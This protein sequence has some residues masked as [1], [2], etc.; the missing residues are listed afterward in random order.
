MRMVRVDYEWHLT[1]ELLPFGI[2]LVSFR[3]ADKTYSSEFNESRLVCNGL[4]YGV[5]FMKS[6]G[7]WYIAFISNRWI[8]MICLM[9]GYGARMRGDAPPYPLPG[10]PFCTLIWSLH[11]FRGLVLLA[12]TSCSAWIFKTHMRFCLPFRANMHAWDPQKRVRSLLLFIGH[13]NSI[14]KCLCWVCLW[15]IYLKS[16]HIQ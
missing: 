5:T 11:G 14:V 8:L 9:F 13:W 4:W 6:Y 10:A 12:N 15:H 3:Y 1:S 2:L 7:F 16:T